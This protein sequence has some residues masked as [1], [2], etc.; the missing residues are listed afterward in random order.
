M[1]LF[2]DGMPSAGGPRSRRSRGARAAFL[3]S[4]AASSVAWLVMSWRG[5]TSSDATSP[6]AYGIVSVVYVEFGS[7]RTYAVTSTGSASTTATAAS[8][9]ASRLSAAATLGTLGTVTS[10]HGTLSLLAG[11]LRL[12]GK[13]NG[14]LA[15]K[16][17]LAGELSDGTLGLARCRKVDKCVADWAVG[18]W[19]LGD[20]GRL[21]VGINVSSCNP[22]VV[23]DHSHHGRCNQIALAIL[24][25]VNRSASSFVGGC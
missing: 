5:R 11:W 22:N 7:G 19:V 15:L 13:L 10:T 8:T 25:R 17:L 18:A 24:T 6:S 2:L 3:S 9:T 12:A 20:G 23:I 21:T 14:D 1:T 4:L 16:D